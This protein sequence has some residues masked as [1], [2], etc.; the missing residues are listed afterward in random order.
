M[1]MTISSSSKMCNMI[2]WTTLLVSAA[3]R[4]ATQTKALVTSNNNRISKWYNSTQC[5]ASSS[6]SSPCKAKNLEEVLQVTKII[7]I[8]SSHKPLWCIKTSR[9]M[10]R[11]SSNSSSTICTSNS[12]SNSSSTTRWTSRPCRRSVREWQRPPRTS[13]NMIRTSSEKLNII[14]L[15]RLHFHKIQMIS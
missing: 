6:N 7:P 4:L 14:H 10:T 1:T 11:I 12:N 3:C 8:M 2:K 13:N 5:S 9:T 15:L